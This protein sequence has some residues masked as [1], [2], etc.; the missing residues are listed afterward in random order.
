M[1]CCPNTPVCSAA[2]EALLR[3][4]HAAVLRLTF[5][6]AKLR[7]VSSVKLP[8]FTPPRFIGKE[9]LFASQDKNSHALVEF[10]GRESAK[11]AASIKSRDPIHAFLSFS[12]ARGQQSSHR[13]ALGSRLAM[14]EPRDSAARV[15][16]C[17]AAAGVSL[18]GQLGVC[19]QRLAASERAR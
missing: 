7:R 17:Q 13:M 15:D 16:S 9:G 5:R 3:D 10:G 8:T 1:S 4:L 6:S 12:L 18:C 19:G 11:F 2:S 14:E